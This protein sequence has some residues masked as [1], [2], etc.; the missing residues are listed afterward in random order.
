MHVFSYHL[1]PATVSGTLSALYRPP[2]RNYV[3]GLIHAECMA[4][5]ALGSPIFSA[6]RLQLYTLAM[7]AVWDSNAA[8]DSFLESTK[9]GQLFISGWHVRMA[10]LRRWGSVKEFDGFPVMEVRSGDDAPVV[11]VTLA[12]VKLPQIPRFIH[13][14]KPV[15]EFVRD[16]PNTTLALA[17]MRLPRT[18]S[19]FSIWTSQRS[20]ADMVHGRS[21]VKDPKRHSHAMKERD[22]KDFH[23]EFTTLRFKPLMEIGTWK[24]RSNFVPV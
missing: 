20:M 5:M 16:H 3:P 15:E 7:F 21:H 19:T 11:A 18:V 4:T 17:A 6:S 2:R 13:W 24:G 22:R 8:I 14:G 1:A 10:L 9:L 12:R 23:F